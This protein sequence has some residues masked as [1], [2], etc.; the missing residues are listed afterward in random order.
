[1]SL[2]III[3]RMRWRKLKSFRQ[4]NLNIVINGSL[5]NGTDEII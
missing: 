3:R 2:W 4:L 5:L 1:M